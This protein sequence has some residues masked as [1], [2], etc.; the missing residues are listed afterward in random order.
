VGKKF[1]CSGTHTCNSKVS[2]FSLVA[3][4][5]ESYF[6][7]ATPRRCV[8]GTA[9]DCYIWTSNLMETYMY[10]DTLLM[11]VLMQRMRQCVTSLP[12]EHPVAVGK[13]ACTSPV[14]D[15][16]CLKSA[17]GGLFVCLAFIYIFT[18]L[19]VCRR[20]SKCN[21]AKFLSVA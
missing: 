17:E 14:D 4:S 21:Y 8:G 3:S 18:A 6:I 10:Y 1:A 20:V 12:T 2:I 9:F 19:I 5:R 11:S 16:T 13:Q 7:G 15:R